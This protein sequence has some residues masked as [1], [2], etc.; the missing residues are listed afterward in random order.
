MPRGI[1]TPALHLTSTTTYTSHT[2][3]RSSRK[4]HTYMQKHQLFPLG[5]ATL[6]DPKRCISIQSPACSSPLLPSRKA[7]G[8]SANYAPPPLDETANL[9]PN[10]GAHLHAQTTTPTDGPSTTATLDHYI[11]LPYPLPSY[12]ALLLSPRARFICMSASCGQSS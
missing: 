4:I 8:P 9:A 11:A 2:Y 6:P 10:A 3:L 5:H 1:G 7:N 12:R